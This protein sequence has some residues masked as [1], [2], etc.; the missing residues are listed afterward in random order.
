MSRAAAPTWDE[1]PEYPADDEIG[2]VVLGPRR[3]REFG[4]LATLREG[5]GMPKIDPFW[6]GRPK[7]L[8]KRFIEADQGAV[9]ETPT[10]KHGAKRP[11]NA[12][13]DQRQPA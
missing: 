6:G 7:A 13:K 5:H 8:V 12:G 10:I 3:A 1:L 4:R 2:A 11:W 9:A